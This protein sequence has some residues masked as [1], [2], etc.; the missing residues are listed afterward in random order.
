MTWF[1]IGYA[2]VVLVIGIVVVK[3]K[4]ANPRANAVSRRRCPI[5]GSK[6]EQDDRLF[7]DEL[8]KK[9]GPSELRIKGCT[10]CYEK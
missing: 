9:N 6:L 2:V 1:I 3:I 7:A 4:S 5:C 8:S 10:Y